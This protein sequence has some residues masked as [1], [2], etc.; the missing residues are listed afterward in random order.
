M[1]KTRPGMVPYLAYEDAAAAMRFLEQAF[2]FKTSVRYDGEDGQVMHA[3]MRFAGGA[4][5]IGSGRDAQRAATGHHDAANRGVYCVVDDV[6][7]HFEA[8]RKAGLEEA[9][10][11]IVFK[12]E[13]TEFGTRR[14]RVLDP[15]GYE[16]SFGT[17]APGVE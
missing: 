6:D 3:E 15:E 16:W 2:G 14:W 10:A 13:D 1:S 8:A 4:I 7:A 17:Y 12:P 11:R 5:M 9:G